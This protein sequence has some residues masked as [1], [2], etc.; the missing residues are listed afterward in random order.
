MSLVGVF[1][2][3]GQEV[4]D[5]LLDATVIDHRQVVLV[6]IVLEEP[7]TRLLHPHLQLLAQTVEG[8]GEVDF[9]RFNLYAARVQ[10]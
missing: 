3:I 7:Y 9:C 5:D 10:R 6:G 4:G 1:D 8:L 2:G